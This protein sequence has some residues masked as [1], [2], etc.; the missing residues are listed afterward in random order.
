MKET[1]PVERGELYYEAA[2][3]TRTRSVIRSELFGLSANAFAEGG[4]VETAI[5]FYVL[6]AREL[7]RV[8][9]AKASPLRYLM[10]VTRKKEYYE[11]ALEIARNKGFPGFAAQIEREMA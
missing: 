6:A 10:H 1:D 11:K 4:M 7:P 5:A 2:D 9:P 8:N 3:L